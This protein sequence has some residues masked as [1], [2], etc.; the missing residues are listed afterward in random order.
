M[1]TPFPLAP[2]CL[3]SVWTARPAWGVGRGVLHSAA[4]RSWQQLD[5]KAQEAG[6]STP[7]PS[8]SV[9]AN[10]ALRMLSS[11]LITMGVAVGDQW[12]S[13]SSFRVQGDES[14]P[15]C[16]LFPWRLHTLIR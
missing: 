3:C 15:R 11:N 4:A 14:Y 8:C 10:G 9:G 2:T 13:P 6:G 16:A 12:G 1:K 7:R 5:E